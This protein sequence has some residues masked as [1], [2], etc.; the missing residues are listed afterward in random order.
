M[1]QIKIN[2]FLFSTSSLTTLHW[3]TKICLSDI[4][5]LQNMETRRGKGAP[6]MNST[7]VG[8]PF[9][10]DIVLTT[11]LCIDVNKICTLLMGGLVV[12]ICAAKMLKMPFQK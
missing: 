4:F 7:Y 5:L 1:F 10:Y 2:C 6:N 11:K 9:S 12:K 8:F 3:S